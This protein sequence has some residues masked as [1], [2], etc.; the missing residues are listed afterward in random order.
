M[1]DHTKAFD[2]LAVGLVASSAGAWGVNRL[3]TEGNS[4]LGWFGVGNNSIFGDPIIG[5]TFG[6]KYFFIEEDA[7]QVTLAVLLLILSGK[8]SHPWVFR[9]YAFGVLAETAYRVYTGEWAF[10]LAG[11]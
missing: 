8:T 3:E 9:L 6:G 5:P 2:I 7:I 1:A 10:G 4:L 11:R